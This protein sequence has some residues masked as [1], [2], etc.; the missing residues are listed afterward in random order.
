MAKNQKK[1]IGK[2]I[3]ALLNNIDDKPVE[4]K[5]ALVGKPVKKEES[6]KVGVATIAISA[7]EVNPAQPRTEFDA[8]ALEELAASIRLHGLIQ[9]ITVR[10]LNSKKYQLISGERR[11]RASKLADLKQIPA[12]VREATEQQMRE[13]ALIEN[14]Q[15]EDLN[16]IEVAICY[17][18]LIEEY[19][20]T[21]EVISERVGKKRSTITNYL[22]LLKLHKDIQEGIKNKKI[23][24]GHARALAGMKDQIIQHTIYQDILSKNLSVRATENLVAQYNKPAKKEKPKTKSGLA[25]DYIDVQKDLRSRL[26]TKVVLKANENGKGQILIPFTSVNDLNRILELIEE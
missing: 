24:M 21:Q 7:I 3:R 1:A 23:S 20:L 16:A 22:R 18:L 11:L 8:E 6:V 26:G 10:R 4:K 25:D 15:R 2:G 19:D 17:Q 9:P 14:I 12:Y 5:G 13:M